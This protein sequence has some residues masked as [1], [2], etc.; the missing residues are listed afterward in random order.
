[1]V[2]NNAELLRQSALAGMGVVGRPSF[3]LRDDLTSG[4]LVRLL[5]GCRLGHV[6]VSMVYPS[7]RFL[8]AKT[9]SFVEFISMQ[10]PRPE[11]D[12]WAANHRA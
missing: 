6:S 9:A 2:S 1:M 3:S 10:F 5:P 7:R 8:P 11:T 4:R 12:P